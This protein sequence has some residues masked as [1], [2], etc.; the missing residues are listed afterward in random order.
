MSCLQTAPQRLYRG[1]MVATVT[2]TGL[3]TLAYARRLKAAG[4]AEAVH[5]AVTESVAAKA[6]VA[7]FK[8]D[9]ACLEDK[10]ATKSELETGMADLETRLTV[11]F[12]GIAVGIV[13][14]NTG[15]TAALLKLLP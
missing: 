9:I 15:L 14:A 1:G 8:A 5:D 3:D 2:A 6:D 10:M 12:F 13:F 4:V 7:A 11:R